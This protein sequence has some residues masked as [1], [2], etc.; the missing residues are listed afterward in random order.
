MRA[1]YVDVAPELRPYLTVVPSRR[2]ANPST[3]QLLLTV[4]GMVG[5]VNSA[6]VGSAGGILAA[7]VSSEHLATS[8]AVGAPIGLATLGVHLRRQASARVRSRP[9]AIDVLAVAVPA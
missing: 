7:A 1:F 4:A 2:R 9:E 5:F 3:A 8:L 6:V